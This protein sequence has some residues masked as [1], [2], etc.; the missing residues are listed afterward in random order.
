MIP[1]QIVEQINNRLKQLVDD[2]CEPG[3]LKD[4]ISY[5]LLG[6][7][8]RIRPALCLISAEVC[9]EA[10][11][12]LD[13]ACAI[14]MIH[15]YSLIHDDL[16]AMDNDV[17]RRG[18]S[19][20]HVV[21]GEGYAILAGDALLNCAF[22]VML[23]AANNSDC[24]GKHIKAMHVIAKASGVKGMI[25]G[26]AADLLYEGKEPDF[27]ALNYIHL[28]KTAALIRASVTSGAVLAGANQNEL[29]AFDVYG[30]SIGLTFQIVDDMLDVYGNER[31]LGKSTGK[32]DLK[33][34]LTYVRAL[35]FKASR[36]IAQQK[37]KQAKEAVSC[38]GK[39]AD[40][41]I[42]IANGLLNRQK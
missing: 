9:G 33:G 1:K 24:S 11:E 32:D 42:S 38:F 29:E 4:A 7:G 36:D 12:A 31:E 15:T 40:A 17:L 3:I 35:G 18:K 37:T 39:R 14:E 10:R 8:K 16:P 21:F 25:A 28:N 22:E 30:K 41:L 34:K 5:S 2:M 20:N 6:G 19:T 26:Q 13:F 23:N 27:E